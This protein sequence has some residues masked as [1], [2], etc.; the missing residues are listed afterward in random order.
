MYIDPQ[1]RLLIGSIAR[2]E[3]E[4]FRMGDLVL[5]FK[6]NDGAWGDFRLLNGKVNT[7]RYERF[8]GLSPDGRFLFFVRSS[9]PG[10]FGGARHYWV[11]AETLGIPGFP[12]L[13]PGKAKRAAK[14]GSFFGQAPPGLDPVKFKT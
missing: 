8:P 4:P 10:L 9:E 2:S 6:Q 1:E 3:I 12:P 13:D 5:S 7:D 11:A 14:P